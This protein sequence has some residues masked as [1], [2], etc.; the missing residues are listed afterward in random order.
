MSK[1]SIRIE[2]Q[3][4][5]NVLEQGQLLTCKEICEIAGSD[6]PKQLLLFLT[7]HYTLYEEDIGNGKNVIY[8]LLR[9]DK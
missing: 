4:V 9:G 3:K 7:E 8:G 5:I 2:A 6:K 1:Q